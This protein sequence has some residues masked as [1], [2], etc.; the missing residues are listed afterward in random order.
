MPPK[1]HSDLGA[2]SAGR[3]L[4]CPGSVRLLL[5][6]PKK[7]SIYSQNGTAQ[8]Y[9]AEQ[10]LIKNRP[11]AYYQGRKI[12][13]KAEDGG[14]VGIDFTEDMAR[15]VQVYLDCIR[16]DATEYGGE[17]AVEKQFHLDWLH[18]DLYGT[19]DASLGVPFGTLRVYD[20]K[21][22]RKAVDPKENPQLMYY[23]LGAIGQ[24]N[25]NEYDRVQLVIVQPNGEGA[26]IKRWSNP[27]DYFFRWRDE[28]LM[29]GVAAALEPDA[30]CNAGP[31]CEKHFCDALPVCPTVR[32][33]ACEVAQ[34]F[35]RPVKA[36]RPARLPSPQSMTD[37]Q[38]LAV[39]EHGSMVE[40]WIDEVRSY[41]RRKLELGDDITGGLYKLV[42]GKANRK[43]T[44]KAEA[45]LVKFLKDKA[46]E[47]KLIGVTEAEKRLAKNLGWEKAEIKA[48]ME[49]ITE[50]PEGALT[51]VPA[52]DSRPA[53]VAGH[54]FTPVATDNL[55]WL[56]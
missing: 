33:K 24:G 5:D 22:G 34:G 21:S 43:L 23:A 29:P 44:D 3:W 6:V 47:S 17:L 46:Y 38:V 9:V 45:E 30:P 36:E 28:V 4:N 7:D 16:G 26:A 56:S 15:A 49:G 41:A 54:G 8:H 52:S 48:F 12:N 32:A 18:E 11:A 50:R 13:V 19:N 53:V 51:L 42:R 40:S 55:D 2:S 31:W 14:V 35:F 20:Y 10:A 27:V 1:K 39:L 25:P 37:E